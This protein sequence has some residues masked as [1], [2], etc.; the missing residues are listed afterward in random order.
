MFN[1]AP[2]GFFIINREGAIE[3]V[4]TYGSKIIGK[5]VLELK[6]R[7]FHEFVENKSKPKVISFFKK[8]FENKSEEECELTIIS[9]GA[10]KCIFLVGNIDATGNKS[11]V[12]A[13]DITKRKVAEKEMQAA[14]E[15]AQHCDKL[16]TL[17]LANLSHEIRTPLNSIIAFS[18]ML[19]EAIVSREDI[20]EYIRIIEAGSNRMLILL[21]ILVNISKL[22]QALLMSTFLIWM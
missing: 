2:S 20:Q 1:F 14:K 5:D 16:K 15:Y 13:V 19:N 9:E 6:G 10:N 7:K 8:I 22:K 18:E 4:N 17:F 3:D 11:L 12:V 21:I